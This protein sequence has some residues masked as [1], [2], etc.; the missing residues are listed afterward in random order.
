VCDIAVYVVRV[1]QNVALK[2]KK[3]LT[4]VR[5]DNPRPQASGAVSEILEKYGWQ[6]LS[7]PLYSPDMS[8][9]DFDLFLKLKKTTP[10]ETLQKH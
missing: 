4:G 3:K 6:V 1:L 9:P 7:H 2:W 8:P 10:W 5:N